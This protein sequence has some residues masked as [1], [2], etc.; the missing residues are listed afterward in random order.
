MELLVVVSGQALEN[1]V[2]SDGFQALALFGGEERG[3]LALQFFVGGRGFALEGGLLLRR[4]F[5]FAGRGLN[6]GEGG[7]EQRFDFG[8]GGVVQVEGAR[9]EK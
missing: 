4:G 2:Q 7:E 6:G 3:D 9:G 1:E 5:R 8:G